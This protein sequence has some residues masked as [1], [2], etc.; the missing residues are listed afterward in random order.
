MIELVSNLMTIILESDEM[1]KYHKNLILEKC[2]K[3]LMEAT[4]GGKPPTILI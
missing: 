4:S 1:N 2:L 3:M